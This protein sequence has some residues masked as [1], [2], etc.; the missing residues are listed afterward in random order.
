VVW[1]AA[2]AAGG[3]RHVGHGGSCV[4]DHGKLARGGAQVEGRVE[5][6]AA[7]AR[8]VHGGCSG[9]GRRLQG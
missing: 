3:A 5:V 9:W 2:V 1:A 6:A 4:H 7:Q 8:G